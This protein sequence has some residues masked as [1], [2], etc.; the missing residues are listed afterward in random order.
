MIPRGLAL[1]AEYVQRQEGT[2]DVG[3]AM[4]VPIIHLIRIPLD[5]YIAE[6]TSEGHALVEA[7]PQ[8]RAA[9][10]QLWQGIIEQVGD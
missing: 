1:S 10:L 8:Y 9:F 4:P 5:H 6:Q 7:L 3:Q 2:L